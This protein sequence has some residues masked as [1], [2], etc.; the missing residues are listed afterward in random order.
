MN[1]SVDKCLNKAKVLSRR[2]CAAHYARFLRQG[3]DF[4]KNTIKD[5]NKTLSER[6]SDSFKIN[7]N[8]C[9]ELSKAISKKGYGVIG[10]GLRG[11]NSRKIVYAHRA[12][13]EIHKGEIPDGICVL[14]SCD[15]PSCIN[16]NHLFLGTPK[17]NVRDMHNKDR[18]AMKKGMI[19]KN[20]SNQIEK[21]KNGKFSKLNTNQEKEIKKFLSLGINYRLIAK[22]Y[23][24]SKSCISD[25][26]RNATWRNV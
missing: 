1:C 3:D 24:V 23:N 26:K 4:D 10:I 22:Q 16:P 21:E 5:V 7:E 17:D 9:H 18:A 6:I 13:Y 14:H 8:G 20:F 15:N 19:P 11:D 25:I 12:S 2:L